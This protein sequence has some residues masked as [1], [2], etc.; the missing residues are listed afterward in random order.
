MMKTQFER[1]LTLKAKAALRKGERTLARRIAQRIVAENPDNLDG[2]LLLGGLSTPKASFAYL[3]IAAELAPDDPRVR[4]ALAWAERRS[5]EPFE[6]ED[7]ERTRRIEGIASKRSPLVR[8]PIEVETH[9]PVWLW[10]FFFIALLAGIFYGLNLIPSELVRAADQAGPIYQETFAKPSLTPTPTHTATSTPTPTQTPT[11]TPTASPT[12]TWTATTTPTA[13]NMPTQ[14]QYP[15]LPD[16]VDGTRW[17]DVDLSAQ[18]LYAYE[19]QTLVQSFLVST[20]T[21]QHPTLTGQYNVYIKLR[22]ADMT[23]PGYYLPDVPYTMYYS[24]SYGIHGT[25]WHNNFGTPMSHGCINM[26]TTD[27]A[28]LYNWSYV[29]IMVNIHE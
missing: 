17:I 29:G 19:G 22:Y 15:T 28:W 16:G 5:G 8:L 21:W 14:V 13:T 7:P 18:R 23:G 3:Q 2:W 25:Y 1:Q 4:D 11:A 9:A 20:G 26:R 24:G 10:M 6:A 12:P 27:A